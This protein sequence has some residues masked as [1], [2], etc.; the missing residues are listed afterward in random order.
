MDFDEN[1]YIRVHSE[2][3]KRNVLERIKQAMIGKR[4]VSVWTDTLKDEV[5]SKEKIA[6]G[7]TRL[8]TM[9]PVD[10]TIVCR[11]FFGCFVAAAHERHNDSF[12][13]VGIDPYSP[14]WT[15]MYEYLKFVGTRAFDGD[16]KQ[17]DGTM[18]AECM[19]E[20]AEIVNRWYED[21]GVAASLEQKHPMLQRTYSLDIFGT[22]IEMTLQQ[23]NRVRRV[24]VNEMIHTVQVVG[25]CIYEKLLGNC[26]GNGLT[27]QINS[28]VNEMYL[29]ASYY[30]IEDT[31]MIGGY[32]QNVRDKTYGDDF[33]STVS[34]SVQK[35]SLRSVSEW[36]SQFGIT[37]TDAAKSGHLRDWFHIS[38]LRFLKNGFKRHHMY[39][40][41][42]M[43][44]LDK[45]SI[46]EMLNW[47]RKSD[48]DVVATIENAKNALRFMYFYGRDDY[49]A[50]AQELR[51]AFKTVYNKP[52]RKYLPEHNF[53]AP[54][55]D[56]LDREF[57]RSF[58]DY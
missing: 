49:V 45:T 52:S 43:A 46:M 9:P 17:F 35:Y 41:Y 15:R 14:E 36:L 22:T 50:L 33:V 1:N 40:R 32:D 2:Q 13:S 58:Y 55:F 10:F 5:V 23:M 24:L 19:A 21:A 27:V 54:G 4:V 6:A 18:L 34:D 20:F 11:M 51:D 29:R 44:T 12:C 39:P 8:F 7:K 3:L 38:E 47:I 56:I 31:M 37:L 26:S 30:A 53:V 16:Y 28:V 57:V 25:N 42:I 48:D